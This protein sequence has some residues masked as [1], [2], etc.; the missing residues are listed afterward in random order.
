MNLDC[1]SPDSI[2]S[3]LNFHTEKSLNFPY[4]FHL[5]PNRQFTLEVSQFIIVFRHDEE[6]IHVK[7]DVCTLPIWSKL[8]PDSMVRFTFTIAELHKLAGNC[9]EPNVGG[10]FQPIKR[11]CQEKDEIFL[12]RDNVSLR[13]FDIDLFIEISV[14]E[15]RFNVHVMNP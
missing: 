14:E 5:K 10:L 3:M 6:I 2:K 13:L 4:I 12:T 11:L 9:S 15:R 7:D 8:D 1:R